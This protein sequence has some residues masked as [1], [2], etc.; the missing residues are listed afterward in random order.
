MMIY[1]FYF[2]TLCFMFTSQHQHRRRHYHTNRRVSIVISI[3]IQLQFILVVV[4]VMCVWW[5]VLLFSSLLATQLALKL[6]SNYNT[7]RYMLENN[8]TLALVT[9]FFNDATEES[10]QLYLLYEVLTVR[11]SYSINTLFC[12]NWLCFYSQS[13]I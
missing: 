12:I 7:C 9:L 11:M 3:L 2:Y 10:V 13:Q 8:D 5:R 1:Y 6:S 4:L